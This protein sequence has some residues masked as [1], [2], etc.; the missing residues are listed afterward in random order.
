MDGLAGNRS[1]V[2]GGPWRRESEM[3]FKRL[4]QEDAVLC[5][6]ATW[7]VGMAEGGLLLGWAEVVRVLHYDAHPRHPPVWKQAIPPVVWE[8]SRRRRV[9][10]RSPLERF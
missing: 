3:S 6:V 10:R 4:L 2:K 1:V 5:V 8:C 9:R 7:C